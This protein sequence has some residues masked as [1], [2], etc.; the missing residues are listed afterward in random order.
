MVTADPPTGQGEASASKGRRSDLSKKKE[1]FQSGK[2][3]QILK[4]VVFALSGFQNPLRSEIRSK[5]LSMGA[6]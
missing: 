2:P 1:S 6:K 4:G 5:A 3:S